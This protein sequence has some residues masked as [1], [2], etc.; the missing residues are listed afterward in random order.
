MYERFLI[1]FLGQGS[2]INR[3]SGGVRIDFVP[4]VED[5][6]ISLRI[7]TSFIQKFNESMNPKP[8]AMLGSVKLLFDKIQ[9]WLYENLSESAFHFRVLEDKFHLALCKQATPYTVNGFTVLV[10]VG[11][12]VTLQGIRT[13]SGFLDGN[14]IT[15]RLIT[16]MFA[17]MST[18]EKTTGPSSDFTMPFFCFNNL[19]NWIRHDELWTATVSDELK[20]A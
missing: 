11:E 14:S 7:R 16:H 1:A 15:A 13:G 3:Q 18:W 4:P 12:R 19:Y 10:I 2:L 20:F 6:V 8:V 9:H 17:H 5:E